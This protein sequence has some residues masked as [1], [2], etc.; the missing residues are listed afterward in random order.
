M[1]QTQTY[2]WFKRFKNGRTSIEDDERSGRPSCANNEENVALVREK[3]HEDRRQ[4]IHDVCAALGLSYGTCQRILSHELG[5]RRIAAKF[6]PRLLSNDQKQHRVSVCTELNE[7]FEND[8]NF[9]SRIIT[10]DETWV[11]G[12]DPETKRQSSQWKSPSSPRPKKAPQVR[13]NIKSMLICFFDIKGIIH[14][15]FVPPRLT[16]NGLFYCEVL[17]RLRENVR[18]KR[19]EM[20][21][22]QSWVL[23]HDNAPAHTSLVVQRFLASTNTTV[24]PHPP[25]SPYLAPCDFFLFPKMKLK[26]KGKRFNTIEEIQTTSQDVV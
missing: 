14:K 6:V 19:L 5:M 11:Y 12:Y 20:W 18:R 4:T 24:F 17:R 8:P 16:V 22:N 23:H 25:Y 15:E 26:L 1:G 13:S 21:T 3:I 2:E 9:I 10:G 7:Q